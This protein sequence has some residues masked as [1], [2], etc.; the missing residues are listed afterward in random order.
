LRDQSGI[1]GPWIAGRRLRD[2]EFV[3]GRLFG[4]RPQT[5]GALAFVRH[6]LPT[7]IAGNLRG[8]LADEILGH[9]LSVYEPGH[10]DAVRL[11]STITPPVTSGTTMSG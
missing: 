10:V 8:F 2:Q 11:M 3:L 5:L 4:G 6:V 7:R 9:E 1:D